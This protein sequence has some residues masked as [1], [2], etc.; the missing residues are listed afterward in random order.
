MILNDGVKN[1]VGLHTS[2]RARVALINALGYSLWKTSF[3]EIT[4]INSGVASKGFAPHEVLDDYLSRY[5][6][7]K[8]S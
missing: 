1:I 4:E 8:N 3:E 6:Y 7:T 5:I 2:Y